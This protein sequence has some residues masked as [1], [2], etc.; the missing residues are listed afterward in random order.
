MK[1]KNDSGV[2]L[3]STPGGVSQEL[4]TTAMQL[5]SG[6]VGDG[7]I[8]QW[9]HLSERV[10]PW[11]HGICRYQI[12]LYPFHRG[13]KLHFTKKFNGHNSILNTILE[14]ITRCPA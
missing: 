4:M 9:P 14:N 1:E 5:E 7:A 8:S 11:V 3:C 12:K 2:H 13:D 10:H 6:G